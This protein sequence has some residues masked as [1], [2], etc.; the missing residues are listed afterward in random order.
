MIKRIKKIKG[1]GRFLNVGHTEIGRLTLIYGPNCYGKSTLSDIFRSIANQ[2]PEVLSNRQSIIRNGNPITQEVCFSIENGIDRTE[3]DISCV[4]QRWNTGN[5]NCSIEVFD[6]RF[7]EDNVFTGLTISRSNKENLTSLLIGEKSVEIGKQIDSLKNKSLRETTKTIGEFEDLLKRG[8]RTLDLGISL[9]DFI[10]VEKPDDIEATKSEL[11]TFQQNLNKFRKSISEKNKILELDEPTVLSLENPEQAIKILKDSLGKGFEDI[12][13]T[14]YKRMRE[15]IEQHFNFH[16]GEE[17]EWIE[18]GVSNYLKQNKELAASNCP[19]CSQSLTTVVALI[20]TYKTVFSEEYESFCNK[21][22]RILDDKHREFN[23]I[24][25]TIKLVE[26]LVNKNLASCR[27]WQGYFTDENQKLIEQLDSLSNKANKSNSNLVGL[28]EEVAG[29]FGELI[30]KKKRK[31]FVS[32]KESPTSD[33]LLIAYQQFGEII[34]QYNESA[35]LLLIE[36][37]T[38]KARSQNDQLI[39]ESEKLSNK[40]IDLNIKV[41]RYELAADIDKVQ[42]LRGEKDKIKQEIKKLQEKLE[43]ENKGFIEQYFQDTTHIFNRL[44]SIDFEIQATYRRRG[45]QPVYEPTIKFANEEITFDRLPFIFSDADRR[46]LAFSIFISK[47]RKKSNAELR[48]TIVFLDDPITSFD[49]NRI[50]QTFIEIKNL[51]TSCHQLIIAAHHSRFLLDTYEKLKG[52]PNVDL[53]FIEIKRDGFGVVFGLVSDPKTRLDPQAREIEKVERFINGDSDINASDVRRSLRPILQKELEWRFRRDLKG[54]SFEGIGDIVT[55][56]KERNSISDKTARKIYDFNDVLKDDHH[57]TT[58]DID[59]D[60][61]NL[62]KNILEF[63]FE[64]LNPVV[65]L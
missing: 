32:I 15:H 17:E 10:S 40:T 2:N 26:N 16:D 36:I 25:S 64:E 18:K 44:G 1:I 30:A 50:S 46:A 65:N 55:K 63:I 21:T 14:A 12:N 49:D 34:N 19:F 29:K 9:E 23:K 45:G 58:L 31:P 47:L 8:L 13:D 7:I 41:K 62:S 11:T 3:Q 61:R 35:K 52:L 42:V 56:L 22:I 4:N 54:V 59:E 6:S 53:K 28:M 27:R 39:K 57:K 33:N 48:N 37:N 51:A 20:E 24:I 38:L 60:T 43:Q 5:F